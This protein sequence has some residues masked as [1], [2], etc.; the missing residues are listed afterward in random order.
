MRTNN[1][2]NSFMIAINK[3]NSALHLL[4]LDQNTK[5]ILNF[6]SSDNDICR[7]ETVLDAVKQM[8]SIK[9]ISLEGNPCWLLPQYKIELLKHISSLAYLDGTEI[10]ETD[11]T[12]NLEENSNANI[13]FYCH[14]IL[15]LPEPPKD[16]KNVQTIHLEVNFPLLV[17]PQ[18]YIDQPDTNQV[19]TQVQD[20]VE[21]KEIND[22]K[23]RKKDKD[24]A[25]KTESNKKKKGNKKYYSAPDEY[26]PKFEEHNKWFKTETMP[27]SKIIEF[28]PVYIEE[29]ENNL[30]SL[31]NCFRSLVPVRIIYKKIAPPGS[32][33]KPKGKASKTKEKK[34]TDVPEQDNEE[35]GDAEIVLKR[36]TLASFYCEL[37]TV[38]W[39]DTSL[40]F[41]WADHPDIGN[42]AIM[43]NGS[44]KTLDYSGA[45]E[46]V[47][48]KPAYPKTLTCQIG[49]GL[50]RN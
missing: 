17:P 42:K 33:L 4:G 46:S 49:F 23:P 3:L 48:P 15:G 2:L 31:R 44:L 32:K 28:P 12:E 13:I 39:S 38:N 11:K 18:D 20:K 34:R 24:K 25:S 8:K 29:P 50:N 10:L 19:D 41:Y 1:S 36:V 16:T 40:D 30:V 7:L 6:D 37:K 26:N 14:R 43:V 35:V 21:T 45:T 47:I 22:K 5:G 27:W 9:N